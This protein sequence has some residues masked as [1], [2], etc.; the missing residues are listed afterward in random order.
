MGRLLRLGAEPLEALGAAAVAHEA[1]HVPALRAQ[2]VHDLPP[3]ES[4]GARD[5]D[6]E[7]KFFQ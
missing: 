2:R 5:E 3:D 6:H 1:A 7:A 4:G